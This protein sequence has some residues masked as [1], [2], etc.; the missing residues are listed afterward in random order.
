[1]G[2]GW[3]S[4]WHWY[5]VTP[6]FA[7]FLLLIGRQDPVELVVALNTGLILACYFEIMDRLQAIQENKSP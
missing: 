5:V 7:V 1:M 4:S 6:L 2:R 3:K